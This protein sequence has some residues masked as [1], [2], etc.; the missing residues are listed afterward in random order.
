MDSCWKKIAE[1][2]NSIPKKSWLHRV[3]RSSH[4]SAKINAL[5][6]RF[7]ES[8]DAFLL[9]SSVSQWVVVENAAVNIS[10]IASATVL[11]ELLRYVAKDVYYDSIRRPRCLD[12]TCGDV[13]RCIED[14]ASR[15][16]QGMRSGYTPTG[17]APKDN[18]PLSTT[19]SR[20]VLWLNGFTG[21]GKSTLASTI[22]DRWSAAE[23]LGATF[24][25]SRNA[26]SSK[27]VRCILPSIAYQLQARIPAFHKSLSQ[28]LQRNPSGVGADVKR[29]LQDL[30]ITPIQASYPS[31]PPLVVV[32]DAL[33]ECE[34]TQ[35]VSDLLEAIL[36]KT[37]EFKPLRFFITSLPEHHI[38]RCF[39]DCAA[40]GA[41]EEFNLN[42]ISEPAAQQDIT[43]YVRSELSSLRKQYRLHEKAL[44]PEN[45][46]EKVE[47]WPHED[48]V[49]QL[50]HLA[51][52]SFIYAFTAVKFVGDDAFRDPKARLQKLTASE[53][54][55]PANV[56]PSQSLLDELYLRI[57][58]SVF[59]NMSSELSAR[60][61]LILGT[62]VLL[63]EPLS[64]EALAPLI[65]VHKSDIYNQC[66]APLRS[67]LS[68]PEIS[69]KGAGNAA[70]HIIHPTFPDFLLS[71]K[72]CPDPNF[73]IDAAEHH[74]MLL[75][76][77]LEVAV[78]ATE[79]GA[80]YQSMSQ[81]RH[82]RYAM[83]H[84]AYHFRHAQASANFL[85]FPFELIADLA[86]NLNG[87]KPREFLDSFS[88]WRPSERE[89][90]LTWSQVRPLD[91]GVPPHIVRCIHDLWRI[92]FS[93]D[94]L[95][96]TTPTVPR[97]V[98]LNS[99]MSEAYASEG[100]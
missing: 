59:R 42:D 16:L 88:P 33:D 15:S 79:A 66:V 8:I 61:R 86:T 48:D 30:I 55:A 73:A 72:R 2:A 76:R 22:C 18:L 92:Y 7:S 26:A 77:C 4:D 95:T 93:I 1:D 38:H 13:L 60:L 90:Y 87:I 91:S 31:L 94:G 100:L 67:V 50:A 89:V 17:I 81:P 10:A 49:V 82:T 5:A 27:D 37:E 84:W 71:P 41:W 24:F 3:F 78:G 45:G 99:V 11:Q 44:P 29:Q 63:Q 52:R 12:G 46:V 39:A 58:A 19:Q 97:T 14:W 53:T 34:D 68:L 56:H 96:T 21:S 28:I 9:R 75:R 70:I 25:C 54:M 64:A 57:L 36:D 85:D 32:I 62:I 35:A 83:S 40:Q 65:D 69:N 80:K 51:G 74:T 6:T 47:V 20:P 98:R 23:I 43:R